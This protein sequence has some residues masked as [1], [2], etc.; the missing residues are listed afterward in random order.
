MHTC[1][2]AEL[3]PTLTT[4]AVSPAA[5]EDLPEVY[6]AL[7]RKPATYFRIWDLAHEGSPTMATLMSPL[8]LMPCQPTVEVSAACR[9]HQPSVPRLSGA[10]AETG[11]TPSCRR[12]Q[13]INIH[14]VLYLASTQH[15]G[16]VLW[17]Q[18]VVPGAGANS[19]RW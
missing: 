18:H 2:A 13:T 16:L 4:E 14:L 12:V 11:S 7:G 15:M 9:Q 3:K 6:T 17:G 10:S 8:K 19:H 1:I 5:L